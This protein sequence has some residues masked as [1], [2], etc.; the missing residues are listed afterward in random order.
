[1]RR[2]G[3]QAAA[4]TCLAL[5]LLASA[6]RIPTRAQPQSQPPPRSG[7]AAFG[8]IARPQAR[9]GDWPSFGNDLGG[10]QYSPLAQVNVTNVGNLKPAW[11]HRSG[12]VAAPGSKTGA[13]ALEAVPIVVNDTLYYCTPFNRVFALDPTTG[14]EKWVFD[15]HRAA[16]GR[17]PLVDEP[18]KSGLCRG[19]AYWQAA[20]PR[21]GVACDKR[22]FKSDGFGNVFA[23]D[24]DTGTSCADFGAA[25]GHPGR[26]THRDFDSRGTGDPFVGATSGPL[27]IG[28]LVIAASGARDNYRDAN[29]GFVRAFDVRSGALRWEF[30][31]IPSQHA[32]ATGAANAWSTLSADPARGLVFV[33]TTS[34]STDYYGATR[35]WDL[36]LTS[37]TVALSA[38]S[39]TPVWH[40]QATH[41]DLFD[42]DL[43]G[44]PLLVTIRRNGRALPVAIQQ[45]KQGRLFVFERETGAPVFPIEERRAPRSLVPGERA[46]PTQPFAALPEPFSRQ[47][48]TE[49]Q[50]W[51]LTPL[52]RAWC[53]REFRK[54]RYEGPFTP[55]SE[56]GS[57]TFPFGGGNWGGVAFDPNT[58]LLIAK[59][60]NLASRVTLV[61]KTAPGAAKRG[62]DLVGTPYRVEVGLFLSP[63]GVPCTP[64]PFGTVS[65]IDMDTGKLRWQVPLGQSRYRGITAPAWFG[66]GS[67]NIGG[68]MVTGGGLVFIAAALDARLRALDVRSGKTLWQAPLAAPGMSVPMTYLARGRQFVVIAAGGNSRASEEISDA[69]MAFALPAGEART[70][71]TTPRAGTTGSR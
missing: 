31:P 27:V 22:I 20:Q 51:G 54:L 65:A 57:L 60:Q 68:P 48:L 46:S 64:P 37:A 55:P 24:A 49:E 4:T 8:A 52:D 7:F 17:P 16:N 50:L 5:G 6:A 2:A 28:D 10:S 39:G 35:P 23:I 53:R 26:V 15:P 25:Q 40:F 3:L 67:P 29:D 44:H 47:A 70:Q 14:A 18:R 56:Q 19:V 59:G 61:P 33:P 11:I 30:D 13:T 43:P 1:M 9:P 58:N 12:D 45:T 71:S 41:H 69:L 34:P 32:H 42:D 36:P 63:L 62:M 21:P 38:S 66:W